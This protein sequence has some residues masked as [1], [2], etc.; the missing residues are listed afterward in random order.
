VRPDKTND[1]ASSSK[2]EHLRSLAEEMLPTNHPKCL[3]T[4]KDLVENQK[5]TMDGAAA[6]ALTLMAFKDIDIN[7]PF[8]DSLKENY[9]EF[10]SWFAKKAEESA[11]VFK[12]EYHR[13]DGF[14]Y[15]KVENGPVD[16]VQPALPRAAR[17]K[18]GTLKIN[19]HG[20]KL[21]ERFIK[22]IFDHAIYN[23]VSEIYLTVFSEHAPLISLIER[24]GFLEHGKKITANGTEIVYVR[25]IY[26]PHNDVLRNYPIVKLAGHSI[27]LLALKPEWHTRLLPDSILRTESGE[28][29]RDVS[30]TNSIHKVYL[31]AMRGI[32]T[33]KRGDVLLIYRTTDGLGA[34]HYRSVATS[35]GVVEDYR[36]IDSFSSREEFMNYC[37]PRSV[38]TETELS[39]FWTTKRFPHVFRFTYNIALRRRVTRATLIEEI[40]LDPNAYWGFL[41]LTHK[42][43]TDIT[44]KGLINESLVIN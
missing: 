21:G 24:Y 5:I 30:H 13:I 35:I 25:E 38:F 27:F 4:T 7:D 19:A 41:R 20:T 10:P 36:N 28:V 2:L 15:L 1:D 16:D 43:F 42:Q 17:L 37:R 22:K 39:S 11:Y 3:V 12:N 8:F 34:A 6:M 29:V 9:S 23:E 14:L 44:Q 18:V 32:E 33:L 40:G 26:R 31:T